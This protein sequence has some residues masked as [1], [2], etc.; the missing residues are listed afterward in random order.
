M[1]KFPVWMSFWAIP[2]SVRAF[3]TFAIASGILG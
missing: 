3:I 2:L 1:L